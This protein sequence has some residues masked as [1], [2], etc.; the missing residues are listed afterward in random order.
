MRLKHSMSQPWDKASNVWNDCRKQPSCSILQSSRHVQAGNFN[1][2]CV[3]FWVLSSH[4]VLGFNTDHDTTTF[5]C[6]NTKT[7]GFKWTCHDWLHLDWLK[8]WD[9]GMC[10]HQLWTHHMT[11]SMPRKW[12][13]LLLNVVR[14]STTWRQ[15]RDHYTVHF[16]CLHP[17]VG[18][19]L[20]NAS[21]EDSMNLRD[22]S[23][24]GSPL[25]PT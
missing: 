23:S 7:S 10:N 25:R 2:L 21:Q 20:F 1:V 12:R 6:H 18:F 17:K 22:R 16:Q 19:A 13:K 8:F 24:V 11:Q 14:S 9:S 5:V 3:L 4:L 15:Q